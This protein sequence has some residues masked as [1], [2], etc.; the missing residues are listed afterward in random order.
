VTG[1]LYTTTASSTSYVVQQIA[2]TAQTG[3]LGLASNETLISYT[4]IGTA[5]GLV[6]TYGTAL[7]NVA[8]GTAIQAGTYVLS[9]TNTGGVW[10]H[11]VMVERL[12]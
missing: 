2:G 10:S 3:G 11:W 6:G 8:S 4:N 7:F 9:G 12:Q 1:G 5:T